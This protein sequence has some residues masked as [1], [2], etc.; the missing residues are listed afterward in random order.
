MFPD[1]NHFNNQLNSENN[2][3]QSSNF[4]NQF[5]EKCILSGD[6]H[7]SNENFAGAL[8]AYEMAYEKESSEKVIN[9]IIKAHKK[10]GNEDK[11]REFK[12]K[13]KSNH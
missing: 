8:M 3:V 4:E 6:E 5:A 10:L 9:R 2:Q 13:L 11:A 7:F 12:E 1:P